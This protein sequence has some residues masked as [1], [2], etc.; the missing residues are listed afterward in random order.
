MRLKNIILINRA[1]F[2][3]LELDLGDENVSVLSGINGA[4]K[5]TII[6]HIVDA[7]YELAKNAF[8]VEFEDKINKF[9]RVSSAI[10]QSKMSQKNKMIF[11]LTIKL[12][13]RMGRLHV[14]PNNF[15]Q[16]PLACVVAPTF[17]MLQPRLMVYLPTLGE[18]FFGLAVVDL[19]RGQIL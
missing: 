12:N 1:P 13:R 3:R 11:C 17:R 10:C 14:E 8:S 9:Y 6:S 18:Y 2:E 5:T 4:G 7:F 15:G 19:L 16:I